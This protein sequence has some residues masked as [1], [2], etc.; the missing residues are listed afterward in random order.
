MTNTYFQ[1]TKA[2]VAIIKEGQLIGVLSQEEFDSIYAEAVHRSTQLEELETT[3]E[4]EFI[5]CDGDEEVD[6]VVNHYGEAVADIT[7]KEVYVF[8]TGE[9]KQLK[10]GIQKV[11]QDARFFIMKELD[12]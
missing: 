4:W 3:P 1:T 2:G 7:D 6:F 9:S 12:L 8:A 11:H 5:E 10:G